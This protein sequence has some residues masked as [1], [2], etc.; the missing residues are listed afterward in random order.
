[1]KYPEFDEYLL[2]GEPQKRERAEAWGVSIGCRE[3]QGFD[4]ELI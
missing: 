3:L 4:K 1:M 2:Q